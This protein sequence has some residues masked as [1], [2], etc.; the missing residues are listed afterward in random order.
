MFVIGANEIG[1]VGLCDSWER[2][3]EGHLIDTG[4]LLEGASTTNFVL[5]GRRLLG[6]GRLFESGRLLDRLR[7]VYSSKK[8]ISRRLKNTFI[9][10]K[11]TVSRDRVL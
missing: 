10:G 11:I 2:G 7:Y 8:N 5:Q 9:R 1:I 6:R 4:R 3:R